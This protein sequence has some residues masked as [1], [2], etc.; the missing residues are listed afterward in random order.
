MNLLITMKTKNK[1]DHRQLQLSFIEAGTNL[2]KAIDKF[3]EATE[4]MLKSSRSQAIA[5]DHSEESKSLRQRVLQVVNNIAFSQNVRH[6]A[7]FCELYH[8]LFIAT[9]FHAVVEAVKADTKHHIDVVEQ[10]GLLPQLLEEACKMLKSKDG[11]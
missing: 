6:K 1:E 10:H 11:A 2:T 4:K 5:E 9:G 7:V 8:N 3:A